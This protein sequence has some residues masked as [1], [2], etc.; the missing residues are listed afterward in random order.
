MNELPLHLQS[1]CSA[2]EHRGSH[3]HGGQAVVHV[4]RRRRRLQR[5]RHRAMEQNAPGRAVTGTAAAGAISDAYVGVAAAAAAAR[6]VASQVGQ[7]RLQW[8]AG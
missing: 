8:H 7:E 5:C 3:A 4:L 1:L 6:A 2:L